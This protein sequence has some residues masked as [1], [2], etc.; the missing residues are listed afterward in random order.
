MAGYVMEGIEQQ[1][2]LFFLMSSSCNA[3]ADEP[4]LLRH[5]YLSTPPTTAHLKA[6]SPETMLS[7]FRAQLAQPSLADTDDS[8]DDDPAPVLVSYFAVAFRRPVLDPRQRHC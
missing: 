1:S 2:N 4:T 7:R 6:E 8:T 3:A 5:E